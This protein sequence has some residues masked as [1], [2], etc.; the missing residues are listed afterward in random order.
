MS[1]P[2]VAKREVRATE[3]PIEADLFG[4]VLADHL[5][6]GP[7][8]YF[9][10]RDDGFLDRDNSAHYFHSWEELPAHQ[11]CLLNHAR[12]H[13]L[14]LGAGAGQHALAL[15]ARGLQVTAVDS[16]PLAVEVCRAR[17]VADAR[18]CDANDL[19]LPAASIDTVLL[20]SNNPGLVGS[21]EG[22]TA[23][24]LRLHN[25]VRPGGQLLADMVEYTATHNPDHLRYHRLNIARGR[26]PGALR[27]HIEYDGH[28]G[29]D[30]DWLLTTLPD[31][32]RAA[33]ATG[34]R[35]VRCVQSPANYGLH[36]VG[37]MRV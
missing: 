34:W 16:S 10:R 13:V 21:P 24:L 26:Y 12:G 18:V 23:L 25:I 30:F 17:G 11:R 14:D 37:L 20:M 3:L 28:R 36:A 7:A 4:R 31:L 5:R 19:D 15:Q 22:L 27:L 32:R 1:T 2:A 6:R 8:D 9:L 29:P 33:E 35:L